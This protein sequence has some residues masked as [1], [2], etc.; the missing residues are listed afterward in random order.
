MT[1]ALC[2]PGPSV[3]I[4]TPAWLLSAAFLVLGSA[5]APR[6]AGAGEGMWSLGFR[7]QGT[8]DF[9]PGN[10]YFLGPELAYSNFHLAGHRF[11]I[12]GAYL[13]SRLEQAF[14]DNI[15]KY[16]LFLL[17]PLWHFRRNA[18]FDPTLQA[19]FGYA[20]FDVENEEIFGDLD[21]DTWIAAVQ[22]GLNFNFAQGRFGVHW[23]FGYNFIAPEG[24]LIYPGVFGLELWWM[25]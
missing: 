9:K 4:K 18:W 19:D 20:R 16:D 24:H 23:H 12:K 21:N 2:K 10:D 3:R 5:L 15:L 7:T 8:V 6:S 22:P 13:T 25:L 14:R 11:Q 17:T 1:M